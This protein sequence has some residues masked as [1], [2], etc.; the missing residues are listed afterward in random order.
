MEHLSRNIV[1]KLPNSEQK[2]LIKK[3]SGT[4]GA[5]S[6]SASKKYNLS[7]DNTSAKSS[8]AVRGV[9][10]INNNNE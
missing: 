4:I 5:Q 6:M 7:F 8:K 10:Q 3:K 1:Y 9:P 2:D